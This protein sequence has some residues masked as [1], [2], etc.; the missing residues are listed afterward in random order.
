MSFNVTYATSYCHRR[1]HSTPSSLHIIMIVVVNESHIKVIIPGSLSAVV[2]KF[3]SRVFNGTITTPGLAL[4]R[5]DP[6]SVQNT[7]QIVKICF[8]HV[9]DMI[10]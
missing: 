4:W 9:L 2:C 8:I 10:I 6:E 5:G 7:N 3:V 1:P